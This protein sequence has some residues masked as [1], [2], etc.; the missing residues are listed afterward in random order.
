MISSVLD[1]VDETMAAPARRLYR[2]AAIPGDGIGP[3]VLDVALRCIEA[4]SRLFDF[5]LQTTHYDLGATRYR[6]T[7][8]LVSDEELAAI[9][10]EDA[11]LLGAVGDPEVPPGIL[12]RGLVLR[13]RTVFDL[14][15][16]VRPG[17]LMPNVPTVLKNLTPERLDLVVLRE[18]TEGMYVS[19]GSRTHGGTQ[20][21]TAVQL[22]TNSRH[23]IE[24]IAAFG[25]RLAQL[26]RKR[27]TLCHKTNILVEAGRLWEQTVKE[28]AEEYPDVTLDYV[29]VDAC[30][31]HLLERPER[32][33]VIVTDNLFGDIVSDL[34]AVVQGGIGLAPSA[35]LNIEGTGPSLFEP[36][37]GSAPDIAGRGWANPAGAV[38]SAA[39]CLSHLGEL[40]AGAALEAATADVVGE[41]PAMGGA[42]MGCST[43]EVGDRIIER[44]QGQVN[45][46]VAP[47]GA[48]TSSVLPA[49]S[50]RCGAGKVETISDRATPLAMTETS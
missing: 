49:A 47:L 10:S 45:G 32:F 2:L 41:L 24:R 6:R 21:E 3:E 48:F 8:E 7:G 9:G 13:L 19:A 46:A 35:N 37:H 44:L 33:D 25:F 34:V 28:V 5:E 23:A 30:C 39:M 26:R 1:E 31:V 17:R 11:I 29:H 14:A 15:V 18:N 38:F 12:E 50:G 42:A 27:L 36:I 22:A 16:N 20:W 43:N 40:D 4:A